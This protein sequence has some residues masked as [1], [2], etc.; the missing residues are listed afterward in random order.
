MLRKHKLQVLPVFLMVAVIAATLSINTTLAAGQVTSLSDIVSNNSFSALANHEIKFVTPTGVASGN[1]VTFTFQSGVNISTIAFGD[2]DFATNDGNVC[3]AGNWTEQALVGVSPTTS[4]WL[5]A[6]SGQAL[7]L[8]SGGVSAIVTLNK[9]VR[10]RIG[11]NATALSGTPTHQIVNPSSGTQYT[12]AIGGT[13]T[14]SGTIAVPILVSGIVTVTANVDPTITFTVTATAN[15]CSLG[16]LSGTPGAGC[17]YTIA[18][19]TNATSGISIS[20]ISNGVLKSTTHN[21]IDVTVPGTNVAGA[22]ASNVE[23][24]G[25]KI[26]I[27]AGGDAASVTHNTLTYAT[28][29]APIPSLNTLII[30]NPGPHLTATE[31]ITHRAAISP[32]TPAG[33][34]TQI[35]TWTAV[36]N[37]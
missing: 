4:Q 15:T 8:T 2:V 7:T 34:Y 3:T 11:L 28:E 17:T 36:G 1:T 22:V 27:L 20:A 25:F 14:D 13:F 12:I 5:A 29:E 6:V 30:N 33:S 32:T 18:H 19:S 16:S 31:T 24:Y 10:I 23:N 26:T 9:C 35:V 37:F 21:F